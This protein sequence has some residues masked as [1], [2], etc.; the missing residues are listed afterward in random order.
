MSGPA[1]FLVVVVAVLVALAVRPVL[2]EI[3]ETVVFHVRR[4]I[5]TGRWRRIR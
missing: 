4:R 2:V 1:L 5:R 3:V